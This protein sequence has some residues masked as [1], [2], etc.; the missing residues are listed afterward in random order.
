MTLIRRTETRRTETP[1]GVMTTLAS[2]TQGGST[3]SLWQAEVGPD[4]SGP[5]HYIDTEQ[6][7][8]VTTGRA[9]IDLDGTALTAEA[10]DTVILP[11]D[12]LRRISAGPTGFTALVTA[13]PEA[14]AGTP[15]S[16]DT[17]VPPWIA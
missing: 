11:A 14:R 15:G 17:V 10:G 16:E 3:L 4:G 1:G 9:Q 5:L 2:P 13:R 12:V 8:T 6:I 7:W